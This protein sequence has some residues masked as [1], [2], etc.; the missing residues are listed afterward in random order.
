MRTKGI[1]SSVLVMVLLASA[2]LMA[3]MPAAAQQTGIPCDDGDNE[4]TKDELVNAILPYMLGEG[5][6]TLDDVGDAA[7]VY[8]H[9]DGAPKAIVDDDKQETTLYRPVERVVVAYAHPYTIL[10]AIKATDKVVAG[11]T[12]SLELYPDFVGLP[13]IGTAWNIDFEALM[14]HQPDLVFLRVTGMGTAGQYEKIKDMNP[15]IAVVRISCCQSYNATNYIEDTRQL[16]YLLDKEE[17]AE[18]FIDYY[19]G[20]MD[21]LEEV[22]SAIPEEDKLRVYYECASFA[23]YPTYQSGGSGSSTDSLI[24]ATGGKNIFSDITGDFTEVSAEDVI[25][26]DPE[27]ILKTAYGEDN[28]YFV[29][30]IA[31]LKNVRDEIMDRDELWN[32]TAV[33]TG[34]VYVISWN[35]DCCGAK[36]GRYFLGIAYIAKCLHPDLDLDPTALHQDFITRFQGM[37]Y[38]LSTHGVFVYHPEQF[39]EGR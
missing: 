18:E 4:L 12:F 2:M 19:E 14:M 36:G 25:R 24:V 33:K 30:D 22:T 38:D 26:L 35:M 13:S 9:W 20:F 27:I 21:M 17:E 10:Q 37:D 15:N 5:A 23:G 8:A 3:I 34:R 29:D 28:G 16:G 31:G 32:V 7:W 11:L 1:I 39:P 6:L